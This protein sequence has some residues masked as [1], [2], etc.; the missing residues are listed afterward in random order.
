[1]VLF[2]TTVA[3]LAA[4]LLLSLASIGF[5]LYSVYTLYGLGIF[6]VSL[7][8]VL[9]ILFGVSILLYFIGNKVKSKIDAIRNMTWK[10]LLKLIISY[11]K[12]K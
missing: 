8:I 3:F 11:V 12:Q 4:F 1:M 5:G 2:W 7:A 10:Q 9:V 6:V